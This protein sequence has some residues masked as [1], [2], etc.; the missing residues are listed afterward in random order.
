MTSAEHVQ[1]QV[2]SNSP[3]QVSAYEAAMRVLSDP[4]CDVEKLKVLAAMRREWQADESRKAFNAAVVRFQ[5]E[6]PIIEKKDKAYDKMYARIDRIWRTIRPLMDKC[7]LAVT[8]ESFK[9]QAGT[10][11]LEGNLLHRDGHAQPL[12]HEVPLPDAIKGM[13]ATQRSGAA[14]TYAKRYAMCSAL[15]I[16]TGDDDD[17]FGGKVANVITAEDA[18]KLRLLLKEAKRT[19]EWLQ[20]YTECKVDEI[21]VSNLSMVTNMIRKVI[22]ANAEKAAKGGAA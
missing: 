19:E 17:G 1:V 12:H 6:C 3:A 22:A 8:W 5:L 10:C 14:E 2:M 20:G 11:Y 18:A 7:G 16:Q 9:E 15:G 21:L 13:N 4:T